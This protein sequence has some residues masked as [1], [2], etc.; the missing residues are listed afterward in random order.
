MPKRVAAIFHFCYLLHRSS[1]KHVPRRCCCIYPNS[2]HA[3]KK[4]RLAAAVIWL[5]Q[6]FR[7]NHYAL[8]M[9]PHV[10]LWSRRPVRCSSWNSPSY[11]REVCYYVRSLKES[12]DAIGIY[13]SRLKAWIVKLHCLCTLIWLLNQLCTSFSCYFDK[14]KKMFFHC[15]IC[16]CSP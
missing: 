14:N 15:F 6:C 4:L 8:F 10:A 16:T 2:P 7:R 3:R 9:P 11:R 5:R 13:A 1:H 12:G